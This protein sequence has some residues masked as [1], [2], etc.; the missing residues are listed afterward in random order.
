MT[1]PATTRYALDPAP[2][3]LALAQ[4]L[5]NTKG[6]GAQPDLLADPVMAADWLN[7]VIPGETGLSPTDLDQLRAFRADLQRLVARDDEAASASFA[8]ARSAAAELVLGVDGVVELRGG[9]SGAEY[10]VS[11][12]L[13]EVLGAQQVDAWRRLKSCRNERCRVAFYDRSRNN[14]GVWHSL[15]TC[16][17]PANL[18]AHRARNKELNG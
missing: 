7:Q 10:V 17:N 14:S 9:G 16:G 5:L 6:V 11:R 4:D 1:W 15:K 3:G 2:A 12:V 18:R 8:V 13:A